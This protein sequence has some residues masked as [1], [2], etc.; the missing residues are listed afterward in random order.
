LLKG[1]REHFLTA[2]LFAPSM[3][4]FAPMLVLGV[5]AMVRGQQVYPLTIGAGMTPEASSKVFSDIVLMLSGIIA[6][7]GSFWV[8][9]SEMASRGTGLFILARRPLSV[10]MAT[11]T[12]GTASGVAAFVF[13][14][15]VI[16]VFT[17]TVPADTPLRFGAA[18]A[19]SII[20]GTAGTLL[21]A[22]SAEL[23]MMLPIYPTGGIAA[24]A[25][26]EST[27]QLHILFPA[28]LAL[29]LVFTATSVFL[30]RRRCTA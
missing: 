17:A 20:G 16:R 23:P 24:M 5:I 8:F 15:T 25:L 2:L 22:L 28:Y 30:W 9:R 13:G 6:G 7:A 29:A 27:D 14:V 3:L 11:T 12:F 4:V 18:V 26:M 10:V 1:T 19:T 21:V